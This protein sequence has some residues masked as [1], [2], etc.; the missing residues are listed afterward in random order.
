MIPPLVSRFLLTMLVIGSILPLAGCGA[1]L[2]GGAA[3][4]T[5]AYIQGDLNA[6][7]EGSVTQSVKAV[8]HA[9]DRTGIHQVSRTVDNLGAHYTL[10]TAQDEKVEI[11]LKRAGK[12]ATDIVIRVGF[13]GDEALSHQILEEVQNSLK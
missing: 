1:V 5:V 4:G 10:R 8:D 2:V 13:F 11:T 3:A 7:L 12:S 9:V 6:V